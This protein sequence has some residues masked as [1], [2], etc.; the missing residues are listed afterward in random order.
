MAVLLSKLKYALS[1]C[2]LEKNICIKIF[3]TI[4]PEVH[5]YIHISIV[6]LHH[7][8]AKLLWREVMFITADREDMG[9]DPKGKNVFRAY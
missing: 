1:L 9:S 5:G 8:V 2:V 4:Y 6:Y 3:L 7:D